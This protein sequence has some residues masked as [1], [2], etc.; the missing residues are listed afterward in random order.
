MKHEEQEFLSGLMDGEW[1]ALDVRHSIRRVCE[2]EAMRAKWSR[3]HLARHAMRQESVVPGGTLAG[4]IAA[5]IADEPTYSNVTAIGGVASAAAPLAP[6]PAAAGGGTPVPTRDAGADTAGAVPDDVRA[7]AVAVPRAATARTFAAG[8]GLAASVAVIT[9]VGLDALD[10]GLGDD[11]ASPAPA[12]VST[13]VASSPPAP[14]AA[15]DPFSLQVPGAPLPNVAFVANQRPGGAYWT[16]ADS[17]ARRVG[18][19]ARLNMLLS[20]H[21]EHSPTSERQGMLPYSR[22][23]GYPERAAGDAAADARSDASAPGR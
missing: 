3:Y 7:A 21:I 12:R 15:P 4:C 13:Q 17:S 22:L 16:A 6:T 11:G 1:Q 20:Q 2:D 14:P 18:S 19:E 9:A 5:A 23:V 10:G 8:F